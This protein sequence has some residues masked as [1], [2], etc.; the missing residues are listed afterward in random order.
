MDSGGERQALGKK[1]SV[2]GGKFYVWYERG[3]SFRTGMNGWGGLGLVRMTLYP[4]V[5]WTIFVLPC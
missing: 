5:N 4:L 1:R 3:C 2:C